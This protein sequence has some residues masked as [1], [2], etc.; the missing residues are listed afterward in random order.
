[1]TM[2]TIHTVTR[3][4]GEE[5]TRLSVTEYAVLGLLAEEPSHGFAL[6][7]AL[8]TDSAV[9]RVL[10]VRRPLVYR[11]LDRLE[12]ASY[13]QPV[14]TEK[15]GGPERVIYRATKEGRRRLEIWLVEP[16]SHVRDLRIEFLLKL[17]FLRRSSLSPLALI[18]RQ[19]DALKPTLVALDDQAIDPEDHVELWR[20]HNAA[21]AAAYLDDLERIYS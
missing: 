3:S 8:D 15:S 9:G 18:Q 4:N 16:V 19:Q 7:K 5:N 12:D 14:A 6:A 17:A 21:A 13:I 11:A 2:D 20:H 1:M 10:T